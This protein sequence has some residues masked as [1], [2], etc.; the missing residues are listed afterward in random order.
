MY[1]TSPEFSSGHSTRRQLEGGGEGA[2]AA[3]A[4]DLPQGRPQVHHHV[5]RPQVQEVRH[6]VRV[7]GSILQ[8]SVSAENISDDFSASN[9]EQISTQKQNL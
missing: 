7:Q 1:L 8:N 5:Q 4:G 9:S 2:Q 3:A 6:L